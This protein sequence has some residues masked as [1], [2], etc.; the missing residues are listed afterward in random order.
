MLRD[1]LRRWPE[2][3]D[4]HHAL[5]LLLVRKGAG[6]ESLAEL[7]RATDLAP[8]SAR[9]VFVFA[10]AL[11][12]AGATDRSLSVL[13][14]AHRRHPGDAQIL[15]ALATISRDA[16]RIDEARIHARK[17]VELDPADQG[18]RALLQQLERRSR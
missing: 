9:Y 1:G 12:S 17:L 5:G 11:N 6:P 14:R 13:E 15:G 7:E 4:L 3:A 18:A 10:I 8:D 16:G 2:D